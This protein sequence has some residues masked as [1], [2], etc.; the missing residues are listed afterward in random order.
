MFDPTARGLEEGEAKLSADCKGGA[1][2]CVFDAANRG[3]SLAD[4]DAIE[5]ELDFVQPSSW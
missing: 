5:R 3:Q 2:G 4:R 1:M